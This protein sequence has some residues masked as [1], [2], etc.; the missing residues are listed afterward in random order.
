ME[1]KA[2][3]SVQHFFNG[4]IPA[5]QPVNAGFYEN[6]QEQKRR[7]FATRRFSDVSFDFHHCRQLRSQYS[8]FSL[9]FSK[10]DMTEEELNFR[11]NFLTAHNKL[12]VKHGVQEL[13][14]SQELSSKAQ[15]WAEKLASRRYIAYCEVPGIGEN[16]TCFPCH[17]SPEEIVDYWYNEHRFY[18]YE[19]PGWQMGTNYFTQIVWKSTKEIGIGCA[20]IPSQSSSAQDDVGSLKSNSD[21]WENQ[22][23][24]VAFYRPAGNNNRAGQFAVNVPRPKQQ[25]NT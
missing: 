8:W 22:M 10:K 24:V 25:D 18:E 23:V 9:S 1:M 15:H 20:K 17:I 14:L 4:V 13:C 2:A 21:E 7:A 3:A 16:I 19:T 6:E 5:G 11:E 12:R